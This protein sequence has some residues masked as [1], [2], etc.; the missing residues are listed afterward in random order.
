MK[1]STILLTLG[2]VAAFTTKAQA[3]DV[4]SIISKIQSGGQAAAAQI[5]SKGKGFSNI[6][7][8]SAE[9][10]ACT[11]VLIAAFAESLC[12]DVDATYAA[13]GCSAKAKGALGG[14]TPSQAM[15]AF[16]DA[17]SGSTSN[18]DKAQV[19]TAKAILAL[20]KKK[21]K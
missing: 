21:G 12:P 9:G 18:V 7:I 2:L 1:K 19:V 13:S 16:I 6:S 3:V 10:A 15:Q 11:N 5:C 20:A 17:K 14:K 8:R 4:N